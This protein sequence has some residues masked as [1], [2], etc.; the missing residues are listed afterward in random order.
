MYYQI[1]ENTMKNKIN[2][3]SS[4]LNQVFPKLFDQYSTNMYEYSK[5]FQTLRLTILTFQSINSLR[6]RMARTSTS[7]MLE[8]PL[9]RLG[10]DDWHLKTN[11]IF[12][13]ALFQRSIAFDLRE[14]CHN[15]RDETQLNT[16][17]NKINT[18]AYLANR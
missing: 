2:I 9:Q 13:L 12:N 4:I 11:Q 16:N 5:H 8:K 17:H 1:H 10:I 15:L 6:K 18:N 3:I 7:R 14:T